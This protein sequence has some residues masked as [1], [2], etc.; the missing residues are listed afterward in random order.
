MRTSNSFVISTITPPCYNCTERHVGCHGNCDDF[1]QYKAE[2]DKA[3]ETRS[4]GIKTYTDFRHVRSS[5][6]NVEPLYAQYRG[7]KFK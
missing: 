6:W 2:V 7:T 4:K 5:G 3:N 1:K